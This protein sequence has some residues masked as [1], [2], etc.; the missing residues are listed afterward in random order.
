VDEEFVGFIDHQDGLVHVVFRGDIDANTAAAAAAVLQQAR[1]ASP[2]V[3][4]D[5]AGVTFVDSTGL[6]A[7][8]RLWQELAPS[9]GTVTVEHAPASVR[10]LFSL[11]GADENI[12]LVPPTR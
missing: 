11:T 9:G 1:T 12:T 3:V 8:I 10:R 7:L 4:I 6:R 5:M 2:N